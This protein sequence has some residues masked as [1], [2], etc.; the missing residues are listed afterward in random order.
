MIPARNAPGRDEEAMAN[1]AFNPYPGCKP[2]RQVRY[3]PAKIAYGS[4]VADPPCLES[5]WIG[6]DRES[7]AVRA[8]ERLAVLRRQRADRVMVETTLNV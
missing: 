3:D 1:T 7:F 8:K 5:W 2:H 6:L 4:E